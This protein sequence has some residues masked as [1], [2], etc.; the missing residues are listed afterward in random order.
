MCSLSEQ[1]LH[2]CLTEQR[3]QD[4]HPAVFA[5]VSNGSAGCLQ[6]SQQLLPT[7][8]KSHYLFNLRDL[9]RV[10][11]GI[12]MIRAKQ[13]HRENSMIWCLMAFSSWVTDITEPQQQYQWRSRICHSR[14]S[15]LSAVFQLLLHAQRNS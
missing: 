5:L 9:S 1:Y 15:L 11:Q 6:V 13:V 10:F 7:P 14:A 8:T 3:D 4:L 12:L 2:A